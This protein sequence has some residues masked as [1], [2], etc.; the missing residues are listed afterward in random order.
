MLV[1]G[2]V[3]DQ[4]FGLE[5]KDYDL[6]VYYLE[7][8]ELRS[9]LKSFGQVNTVGEHFAVYKLAIY[10]QSTDVQA[11]ANSPVIQ[12]PKSK[13]PNQRLEIDVSIPRR[14]SKAGRGHRGFV[15][16]GDP[17]MTFAEA[18]RRRDFTVNA[19]MQD[20]LTGEIV[21]PYGGVSDI[22][23]RLIRAV[24]AE[25]FIEDSLRVLRALQMAARFDMSLAPETIALCRAIDLADLPHERIWGEFE[26]L[27]LRATKPARGLEAAFELGVL[28]KLFPQFDERLNPE[29]NPAV[30][31]LTSRRLDE[32]AQLKAD[33][34]K[35]KQLTLMLAA[36]CLDLPSAEKVSEVLDTLGLHT[37]NHYD[38]R[39]QI[40][41]LV[42]EHPTLHRLYEQRES[43]TDGEFRRLA[44]RVDMNLLYRLAKANTLASGL[45]SAAAEDWF[46]EKVRVLDLEAGAPK[47]ILQ[48]RHLLEIGIQP[49]PQMGKILNQIYELQLDGTVTTLEEALA[50]ARVLITAK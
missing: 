31:I 43:T 6:E 17:Q 37:I 38:V 1:G 44:R 15:I 20:P 10:L 28:E 3:R 50:Q 30:F 42:S 8:A 47:A 40:L 11:S 12:N 21:D 33:L 36:W 26:K 29:T 2:H 49:G 24:A 46:I 7:P 4:L 14:E 48:G 39:K 35:E 5:S 13:I 22:A 18:A 16:E 25:T 41:S 19:I 32:A 9:I 23:N 34:P 27:F 45:T